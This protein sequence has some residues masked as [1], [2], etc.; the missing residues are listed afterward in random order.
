MSEDLYQYFNESFH[1][2]LYKTT[3]KEDVMV[4]FSEELRGISLLELRIIRYIYEN[5]D[6]IVRDILKALEIPDSTLTSAINR[7]EKRDIIKR[8]INPED[9]R[10]Y[11]LEITEYGNKVQE[12]HYKADL[13][14]AKKVL[15]T[16]ENEDDKKCF[17]RLFEKMTIEL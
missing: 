4:Q 9:R 13:L 3:L 17:A 6:C 8:R 11:K 16:L 15:N 10:S 2:F 5:P 7:L 14:F 12:E 1:R